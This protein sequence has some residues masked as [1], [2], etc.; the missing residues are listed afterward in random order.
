MFASNLFG[1]QTVSA[2]ER[3]CTFDAYQSGCMSMLDPHLLCCMDCF[4]CMLAARC[5]S[6]I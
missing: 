6:N 4:K 5:N 1:K 3:K 2:P